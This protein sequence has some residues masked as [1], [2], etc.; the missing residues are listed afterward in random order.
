METNARIKRLLEVMKAARLL[1]DFATLPRAVMGIR[2]GDTD[3]RNTAFTGAAQTTLEFVYDEISA[4][5]VDGVDLAGELAEV[6]AERDRLKRKVAQLEKKLAGAPLRRAK[7]AQIQ[8]LLNETKTTPA[9]PPASGPNSKSS[10]E[11]SKSQAASPLPGY[12]ERRGK[13]FGCNVQRKDVRFRKGGFATAQA[14]HDYAV[15]QIRQRRAVAGDAP[16]SATDLSHADR[17]G[18]DR[19]RAQPEVQAA[20]DKMREETG[21]TARKW[22]ECGGCSHEFGGLD[23]PVPNFCPKCGSTKV[24]KMEGFEGAGAVKV[25]G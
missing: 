7:A 13:K 2:F 5:N 15:E 6:K 24:A 25:R 22:F 19:L 17:G 9:A 18:P 3:K 21:N 4:A 23:D 11:N 8:V 20:I 10:I 12:V 1:D 16:A 14:A